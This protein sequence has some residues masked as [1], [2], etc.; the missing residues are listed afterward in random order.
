MRFN[1]QLK[2]A[3]KEITGL[4]AF[5]IED[6]THLLETAMESWTCIEKIEAVKEVCKEIW[7]TEVEI[8]KLT[9]EPAGLTLVQRMVHIEILGASKGKH[10]SKQREA[11]SK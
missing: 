4:I 9:E 3:A 5:Q 11:L 6:T 7:Q 8:V 2:A 10:W 1:R